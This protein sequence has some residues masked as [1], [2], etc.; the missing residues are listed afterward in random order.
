MG[1]SITNRDKEYIE[2]IMQTNVDIIF[3]R[4]KMDEIKVSEETKEEAIAREKNRINSL[5]GQKYDIFFVS[6]LKQRYNWYKEILH[7]EK[8]LLNISDNIEKE[9]NKSVQKYLDDIYIQLNKKLSIKISELQKECDSKTNDFKNISEMNKETENN[10]NREISRREI[11]VIN[12]TDEIKNTI[13]QNIDNNIISIKKQSMNKILK[14]SEEVSSLDINEIFYNQLT[15]DFQRLKKINFDIIKSVISEF[16]VNIKN[17][18]EFEVMANIS[19]YIENDELE[20]EK[21]FNELLKE[22]NIDEI[23]NNI[24][25]Y[26]SNIDNI[27]KNMLAKSKELD[28]V[29]LEL[30][31][32]DIDLENAQNELDTLPKYENI[33]YSLSKK[34]L[35]KLANNDNIMEDKEVPGYVNEYLSLKNK[36]LEK[37]EKLSI[38]QYQFMQK[39]GILESSQ[40]Q[41]EDLLKIQYQNLKKAEI[42]IDRLNK[43]LSEEAKRK[44]IEHRNRELSLQ[45][46]K[47]FDIIYN[48]TKDDNKS[49]LNDTLDKYINDYCVNLNNSLIELQ[50]NSK[51][52]R[53]KLFNEVSDIK[54]QLNKYIELQK[55]L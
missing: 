33:Y 8:Y 32:L 50:K 34:D 44:A 12:Q 36:I 13:K 47:I 3:I 35:K 2:K 7:L 22:N 27:N 19:S 26:K 16:N 14:L 20:F 38:K 5:F 41:N 46:E 30:E 39:V 4:T 23:K 52:I 42:E 25:L 54:E 24:S 29:R 28:K 37:Y 40:K 6:N 49:E 21:Y 15:T 51:L 1:K 55:I 43:K 18:F 10:I 31:E 53:E 11:E 9:L 48:N 17:K 45:Y